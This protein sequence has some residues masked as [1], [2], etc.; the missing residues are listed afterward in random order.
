MIFS[1]RGGIA[2]ME[3]FAAEMI[4][5]MSGHETAYALLRHVLH[6]TRGIACPEIRRSEN[7][8]PYFAGR[9]DLFF[10]LSHTRTHVLVALSEHEIGADIETHR[11]ITAKLR[12]RLFTPEEQEAFTFFEGWTLREAVFKLTGEGGLMTM[13]LKRTETEILTPFPGVRCRS[14]DCVPGCTAA[15]ACRE[16]DFPEEIEIVP[17]DAFLS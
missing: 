4:P 2:D 6:R 7:G 14:Y 15:V 8:K 16:G 12:D 3:L 13:P 1:K 11:P 10:S 5:G 9:S 17:A